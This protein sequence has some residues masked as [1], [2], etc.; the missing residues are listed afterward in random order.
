MNEI[1]KKITDKRYNDYFFFTIC[2]IVLNSN[3]FKKL[4]TGLKGFLHT[5]EARRTKGL[6]RANFIHAK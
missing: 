4:N 2:T 3:R 5:T 6:T 1:K